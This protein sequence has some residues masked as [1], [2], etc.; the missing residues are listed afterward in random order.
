MSSTVAREVVSALSEFSSHTWLYEL[1]FKEQRKDPGLLVEAFAADEQ[2]LGVGS[3]DVFALSTRSKVAHASLLGQEACLQI[4]LAD[5]ARARYSGY[6]SRTATL[7]SNGGLSRYRFGRRHLERS[8]P[9]TALV[10][11]GPSPATGVQRSAHA[12][13]RPMQQKYRGPASPQL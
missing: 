12:R 5:G 9:A 11:A 10:H 1:T 6:L 7:G 3:F 4:C 2:L 13:T 8:S